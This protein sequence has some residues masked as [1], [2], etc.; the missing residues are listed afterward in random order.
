VLLAPKKGFVFLAM[1]K[2][3]STAIETAFGPHSDIVFHANP[4]KHIG[5][6]EFQQTLQPF[7]EGKGFPRTSY[8]VVCVFRD[9]MDWLLSWWRFRSRKRLL[10]RAAW[11]WAGDVSSDEFARAYMA[12]HR[13]APDAQEK[14]FAHLV[15]PLEVVQGNPDEA[16]IDLIF[17]YDRL[18]LLV[19]YLSGKVDRDIEVAT[20]NTSPERAGSWSPETERELR[21]FFEPEYAIYRNA[22]AR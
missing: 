16:P 12:Y 17:R 1:T 3:A 22:I 6:A 13:G 5:Y 8:E 14:R 11:K 10:K 18:D 19:D 20:E 2:S 21:E 15:R 9:P 7:L 4:F